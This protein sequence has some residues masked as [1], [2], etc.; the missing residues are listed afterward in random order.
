MATHSSTLAWKI[1]WTEEPGSMESQRQVKR[2][3]S[4]SSRPCGE[5]SQM[6]NS[7]LAKVMME[8]G[9]GATLGVWEFV[10]GECS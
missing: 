7:H 4:S 10:R 2:L 8:A 5:I 6:L 3:S 9:Q 1:P